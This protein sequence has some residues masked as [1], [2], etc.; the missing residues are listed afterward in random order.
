MKSN[1]FVRKQRQ[2]VNLAKRLNYLLESRK[3]EMLHESVKA[4]LVA[5]LNSL[6][7]LLQNYFTFS[8]I[9]KMVSGAIVFIALPLL[10]KSQTFEPPVMNPFGYAVVDT[11]TII[12]PVFADID[13]DE[14]MDLFAGA[15]GG[16]IQFFQNIGS[17]TSPVFTTPQLNPFGL[18][19]VGEY[20]FLAQADI[21]NDGDIDLFSGATDGKLRYYKNTGTPTAPAFNSPVINPF[22]YT[23]VEQFAIPAFADIDNDGDLDLFIC[24]YYGVLKYFENNG[25]AALPHFAAPVSDPFGITPAEGF[26]FSSFADLDFDGDLDL[27]QGEYYGNTRYFENSGS[28][29]SPAFAF[30]V[31]NPFGIVQTNYYSLPALADIDA[32]GDLDLFIAEAYGAIQYF[33]NTDFNVGLASSEAAGVFDLYPN[34]A[35]DKVILSLHNGIFSGSE[36]V[37]VYDFSGRVIIEFTVNSQL[38]AL[39]LDKFAPGIYYVKVV[40]EKETVSRKLIVR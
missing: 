23:T 35:S 21:D 28:V 18:M 26:G 17:K 16:S 12:T 24:E 33:E 4:K 39:S 34:P 19:P 2:L 6:Y 30:P 15:Y 14:D 20:I 38:T 22:G 36:K 31:L 8:S 1:S 32:D 11:N 13:G 9:K 27:L 3:W 25:T 29:T 37:L 7:Q 10:S 40:G 5:K